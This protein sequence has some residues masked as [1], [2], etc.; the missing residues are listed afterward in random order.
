[1]SAKA[2]V[3]GAGWM[4]AVAAMAY[5]V[6][7]VFALPRL[8]AP[9][10]VA[11]CAAGISLQVWAFRDSFRSRKGSLLPAALLLALMWGCA[12][13]VWAIDTWGGGVR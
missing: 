9:F 1:M 4:G 10:A 2:G 7:I 8:G 3:S 12:V 11:V 13:V 6:A 5:V